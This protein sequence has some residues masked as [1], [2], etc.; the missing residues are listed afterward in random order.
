M[1]R[2]V[3][4]LSTGETH[5]VELTAEEMSEQLA[6]SA[7]SG[8]IN[9]ERDRRICQGFRFGDKTY[10]FD[11]ASKQRVTG[12]GTLAG[13]AIVNGAQAGDLFWHGGEQPFRWIADDNSLT[14]MDAETCFAFAQAAA[15][16]EEAHIFAAR[17]LKDQVPPPSDYMHDV[18]WP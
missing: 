2:L 3:H 9:A 13:F 4:D 6:P 10:A 15:A 7:T 8:Q 5:R 16:H 12:A 1:H 11:P 17:A 18:H 14:S